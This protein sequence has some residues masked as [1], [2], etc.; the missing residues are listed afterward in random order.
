MKHAIC[1]WC[2]VMQIKRVRPASMV[3]MQKSF[4]QRLLVSISILIDKRCASNRTDKME[5]NQ[6]SVRRRFVD[7]THQ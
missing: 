5:N 2:R 1:K 6:F 7:E 4:N 3:P